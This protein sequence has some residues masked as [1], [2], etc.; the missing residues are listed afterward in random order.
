M[1][2]LEVDKISAPIAGNNGVYIVKVT[3]ANQTGDEDLTA[4]QQ[5]LNQTMFSRANSE[6]YQVQ[7]NEADIVDK[8]A[9]FY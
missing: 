4:E 9:K 8:R 5:R 1:A 3:S 2:T 6:A 7:K